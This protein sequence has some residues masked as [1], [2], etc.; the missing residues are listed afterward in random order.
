MDGDRC[1]WKRRGCAL[2]EFHEYSCSAMSSTV[3]SPCVAQCSL[4]MHSH[5]SSHVLVRN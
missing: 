4:L 5:G 2:V 3:V 1:V